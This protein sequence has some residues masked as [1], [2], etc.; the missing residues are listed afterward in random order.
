[1]IESPFRSCVGNDCSSRESFSEAFDPN[2]VYFTITDEMNRSSG[3]FT[4]VLGEANLNGKSIPVAFLDKIQNL[5]VLDLESGLD[6]LRETLAADGIKLIA[7][8]DLG[9]HNGLSNDESIK[10]FLRS[11]D[12]LSDQSVKNFQPHHHSH[13][14]KHV[15][16]RA[17]KNLDWRFVEP[18]RTERRFAVYEGSARKNIFQEGF[19][20][21]QVLRPIFDLKN[22]SELENRMRY[23][24]SMQSLARAGVAIDPQFEETLELWLKSEDVSFKL[25]KQAMIYWLE[26]DKDMFFKKLELLNQPEQIDVIQNT[27]DTPRYRAYLFQTQREWGALLYLFR[28]N[29]AIRDHL[30]RGVESNDAELYLDWLAKSD[31]SLE[32]FLSLIR[33]RSFDP[34][35]LNREELEALKKHLGVELIQDELLKFDSEG[36]AMIHKAANFSNSDVFEFLAAELSDADFLSLLKLPQKD[37]KK[38]IHLLAES[39]RPE[40][41]EILIIKKERD[42]WMPLLLE[43]ELNEGGRTTSHILSQKNQIKILESLSSRLNEEEFFGLLKAQ[44]SKANH[45]LHLAAIMGH[46]EV[47]EFVKKQIGIEKLKLLLETRNLENKNVAEMAAQYM[48]SAVIHWVH[49]SL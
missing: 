14:F 20:F 19:E 15:H 27:L 30:L 13:S 2:Y 42:F 25:K 3:L 43:P 23:I 32:E 47:F 22:D 29:R 5:S 35:F 40:T 6:A 18:L 26:T 38:T 10:S 17:R 12:W 36:Q 24:P 11:K 16:T 37:G 46:L 7:A 31:I 41:F 45:A 34:S 48:R 4:V 33:S 9:D 44:D 1:M 49:G 28:E 8:T 39:I 21:D